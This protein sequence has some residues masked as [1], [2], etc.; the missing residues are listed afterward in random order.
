MVYENIPLCVNGSEASLATYVLETPKGATP[1]IVRPAMIVCPGGGYGHLATREAEP[2]ALAF[3]ARGFSSFVLSYSV[4]PATYP[5]ALEELAAAVA[6]VRD[7]AEKWCI[8][9]ERIAVS[10]FSAGGHLAGCLGAF[11]Q[12]GWLSEAVGRTPEDIR[13][14][15]LVLGYPVVTSGPFG[16]ER[17]FRVLTGGDAALTEELSLE[18]RVTPHMPPTFLWHTAEDANVPV[19]N[20]LLLAEALSAA[21]VTFSLHV[22]PFGGHGVS[23]GVPDTALE[24]RPDHVQPLVQVW[25]DLAAA[26]LRAL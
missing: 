17:S 15:A 7:R 14:N 26:W 6:L 12:E 20:S 24:G 25:P 4:E 5:Q 18:K 16:H 22:F 2:I 11:W 13:P 10:G 19:E 9:P 1:G 3:A 21:G 23:L 8:D